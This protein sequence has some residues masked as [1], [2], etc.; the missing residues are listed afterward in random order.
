MI[1]PLIIYG[2]S[3]LPPKVCEIEKVEVKQKVE[4]KVNLTIN[5]ESS[6]VLQGEVPEF[7]KVVPVND[8]KL[9]TNQL[10][11]V[12]LVSLI[13]SYDWDSNTALRIAQCES[14][15]RADAIGDTGIYPHSYGVFQ[16]RALEGRP[17]PEQLLNP[18]VNVDYAYNLWKSQGW[19]PWTCAKII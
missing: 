12:N 15:I 13:Q 18:I 11:S 5:K 9:E 2:E 16:I 4:T 7:T 10:T 19:I 14:G 6:E 8:N 1:A 3:F 17:S